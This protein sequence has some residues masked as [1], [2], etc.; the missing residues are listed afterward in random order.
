MGKK[1]IKSIALY[2]TLYG[3]LFVF[4]LPAGAATDL[5]PVADLSETDGERRI[6]LIVGVGEYKNPRIDDLKGPPNDAQ[7][8]YDLLTGAK[9]HG[10]GFPKENVCLLVNEAAT[11][12]KVKEAFERLLVQGARKGKNDVAVFYYAGHGSQ[13]KD[14]DGDEDDRCD[15]TFLLH[16]ARTGGG[17]QRIGDLIDDD[18]HEMLSRLH[19]K[20]QHAVVILDSCNSG[21][22]TRGPSGLVARW[23]DPDDP[24]K[25]CPKG[26]ASEARMESSWKP[27][28]M[29]GLVAFTAASDGTSALEIGGQGIFT[30]A[31]LDVLT[32]GTDAP[33]TYA[34]ISRQVPPLVAAA[35][36]QIP[37]FQGDLNRAV[38]DATGKR[39]PLGWDVVCRWREHDRTERRTAARYGKRR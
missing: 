1:E 23:Q 5:C 15:E 6:A 13:V 34:Q 20:T 14:I 22:A 19:E 31:L 24:A 30:A 16:D 11:T 37:Y 8:M 7:Q 17:E 39:R 21:T 10:Y 28:A 26:K 12:E 25:A 4:A 36:Y 27:Q 35:S 29:P 9:G 38:F 3:F 18:F 2:V 32:Q 33:L